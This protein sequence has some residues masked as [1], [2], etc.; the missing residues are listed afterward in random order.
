MSLPDSLTLND[1][2]VNEVYSNK[3]RNG[4]QVVYFAPSP[5]G[6]IA[7]RPT[8]TI[9]QEMTKA[10]IAKATV[11]LTRPVYDAVFS[12]YVGFLKNTI[13]STQNGK[14][15]VD[16]RNKELKKLSVFT[17]TYSDELA[18]GDL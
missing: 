7:G 3:V 10:G 15:T 17:G 5:Q 4:N 11:V 9:S 12:K 1:G 13:G 6:D 8:L 18:Y 14:E 2:T 16:G